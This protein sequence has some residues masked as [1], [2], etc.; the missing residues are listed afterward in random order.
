MASLGL[1][2]SF[3][4]AA[5]TAGYTIDALINRIVD[6]ASVR[7]FGK[8]SSEQELTCVRAAR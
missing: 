8:A 3:V 2:G 7:S 1:T 6:V 4:L 5:K